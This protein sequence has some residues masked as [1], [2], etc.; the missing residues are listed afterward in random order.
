M[1]DIIDQ[2]DVLVSFAHVSVTTPNAYIRPKLLSINCTTPDILRL[3]L[4]KGHRERL[5]F[6]F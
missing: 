1:N 4:R 3:S 2:L 6:F 5:L